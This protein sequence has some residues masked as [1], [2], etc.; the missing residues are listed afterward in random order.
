MSQ[1]QHA[2]A[3]NAEQLDDLFR[4]FKEVE[5]IQ[6][7]GSSPEEVRANFR[8]AR[9]ARQGSEGLNAGLRKTY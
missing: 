1:K 6:I 3:A 7:S 5:G 8:R 9:K 2:I 4:L